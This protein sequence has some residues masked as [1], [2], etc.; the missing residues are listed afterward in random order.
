MLEIAGNAVLCL[1]L[2]DEAKRHKISV[3]ERSLAR[4]LGIPVVP[5]SARFGTGIPE[6]IQ[7][8]HGVATSEIVCKPYR[9]KDIPKHI[10]KAVEKLNKGLKRLYPDLLNSRWIAIRLL[11]GDQ[12]IID[13]LRN[14][15]LVT[16]D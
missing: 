11:E 13:A 10:N 15:E 16:T 5:T 14:N 9:I 8:I 6:L 2:I 12:R 4:D 7:T 1:N 3:D